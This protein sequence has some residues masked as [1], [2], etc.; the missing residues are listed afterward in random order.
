MNFLTLLQPLGLGAPTGSGSKTGSGEGVAGFEQLMLSLLGPSP[1]ALESK[2]AT[3]AANA[4]NTL[5]TAADKAAASAAALAA[6]ASGQPGVPTVPAT[7]MGLVEAAAATVPVAK[8]GTA[9]PGENQTTGSSAT[10]TEGAVSQALL[11]GV[12]PGAQKQATSETAAAA[13]AAAAAKG[14]TVPGGDAAHKVVTTQA[15]IQTA[16]AAK[17]PAGSPQPTVDA[18]PKTTDEAIKQAAAILADST[19]KDQSAKTGVAATAEV[20]KQAAAKVQTV[21]ATAAIPAATT[22]AAATKGPTSTA[23]TLIGGATIPAEVAA[24]AA[25]KAPTTPSAPTE[26]A[27]AKAAIQSAVIHAPG[28]EASRQAATSSRD[29]NKALVGASERTG[30]PAAMPAREDAVEQI[31][32]STA[33]AAAARSQSKAGAA[34]APIHQA[35]GPHTG[36]P[37]SAFDLTP[38][39]ASAAGAIDPSGE[40]QGTAQSASRTAT[41][42]YVPP[43]EQVAIQFGRALASGA[44]QITIRLQPESLGRVDVQVELGKDGRLSA[45]FIADRPETLDMLQRDARV[46]ER[47]LSDAGLRTENGGLSFNLRGDGGDLPSFADQSNG[48]EPFELS[49]DGRD[50]GADP[51]VARHAT[52]NPEALLDIQV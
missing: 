50:S 31:R 27:T 29:G 6:A 20:A 51:L 21:A 45:M 12:V 10:R 2:A 46:L 24:E 48:G 33:V 52:L 15:G 40:V 7:P 1:L 37:T 34:G 28:S 39:L 42:A 18:A 36:A 9:K 26:V 35:A 32:S 47:A 38:I 25:A 23:A 19:A 41:P 44:D 30:R 3:T 16:V 49:A 5:F 13:A 43:A 11:Q 22:T 8:A 14:E 17:I 4:G